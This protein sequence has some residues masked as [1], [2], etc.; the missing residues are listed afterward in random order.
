MPLNTWTHIAATYDG[1]TLRL[2]V[3]G[4]QTSTKAVTGSIKTSTG[5]LRFG[6]NTSWS[7][8]WFS[9]LIDEV[10][11]YNRALTAAEIQTDMAAPVTTG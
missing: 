5:A 11:L 10:R 2:F 9:G 4:V 3:N 1:T 7:D 6:G 8:E